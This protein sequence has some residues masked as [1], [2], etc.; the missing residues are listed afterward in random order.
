MKLGIYMGSFNPV[1]KGH[2]KIVNHLLNNHYVDKILIVPT[3][4]YWDKQEL[5]DIKDRIKMLEL[6]ENDCIMVDKENNKYIYTFD[7]INEIKKK[8]SSDELFLI[9]GADNIVNFDKWKNYRELLKIPILIIERN[10]IDINYYI[11]RLGGN[12]F[13]IINDILEMDISS[14]EIRKNLNSKHLD[15]KVLDYIKKN[16]LYEGVKNAKN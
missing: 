8:Y 11:N 3:L 5:I 16:K 1:H 13:I 7:L 2:I 4:N 6:Y 14:S 10:G 9:I 12:N 15:K